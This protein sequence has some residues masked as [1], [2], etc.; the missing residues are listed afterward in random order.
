MAAEDLKLTVNN[1]KLRSDVELVAGGLDAVNDTI[2]GTGRGQVLTSARKKL[3]GEKGRALHGRGIA[4]LLQDMGHD[5]FVYN[6]DVADLVEDF[7]ATEVEEAIDDAW[8]TGHPATDRVRN[9]LRAA[10]EEL[11]TSARQNIEAGLLGPQAAATETAKEILVRKGRTSRVGGLGWR[12]G[13]F[14]QGIRG[15]WTLGRSS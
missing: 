5:A 2:T 4:N 13:R 12:T 11:A 14:A 7:I 3:P 6:G 9:V 1:A 15:F 8:R 10:A